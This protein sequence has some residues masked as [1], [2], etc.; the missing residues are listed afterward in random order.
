MI[1]MMIVIMILMRMLLMRMILMMR[2]IYDDSESYLECSSMLMPRTLS[3]PC[4]TAIA[5]WG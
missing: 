5:A 4:T 2:V 3:R 1:V